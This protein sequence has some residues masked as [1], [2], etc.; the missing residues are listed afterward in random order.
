MSGPLADF[1][2]QLPFDP[3]PFQVEAAEAIAQGSSV[4]VTAPTG[5]GKTVVAEAAIHLALARGLR[6]FYTTPIKALSNQKFGDLIGQYGADRVGLLTGDN[7]IN[8]D[9]AI[10]VMTTE[11][12]RNMIYAESSALD[13]VAIVVL[14]EVHYLQDRARGAVWEEVIIHCP[15]EVQLVCLSAT[16]ANNTEF[17]ACWRERRGSGVLVSTEARPVPLEP[18]YM[19]KERSGERAVFFHPTFVDRD[20]RR[21][22]NPR[23][24]QLLSM[25][26]GRRRRFKTPNRAEVV[27]RLHR[28]RMLPAIYFIFSRAGCDAAAHRLVDAGIRLTT[29]EERSQIRATA[30]TR[31]AHLGDSDL[32]VLGY[33]RWI[34][35]LEAGVA[36]HHAGLVPAFKET[37]EEL[38]SA[39]LVK[40]VFATET[41]ALGINM[42]ARSVVLENL[43][44]YDGEGHQL[45]RPGDY[46][47]LTGRAGRRGIDTEG[48]GV[49][50]HSPFVRFGQVLEI[51]ATGRHRLTSSFRPTYNMTANLV[52]NYPENQA[53]ELL[54][55]SFA[56]F[57]REGDRDQAHRRIAA[58]EA[59]LTEEEAQARCDRGSVEEYEAI[60]ESTRPERHNDRIASLMRSGD[61]VDIAG[62]PRDGR[63]AV[64]K[65]LSRKGGGT[66]Y[67]VLSTSGRVSTMGFRE[68][69][70]G[71]RHVG[72]IDLPSPLRP[73]ERRFLQETLRRLRKLSLRESKDISPE[74]RAVGH[75]VA[76]CPDAAR[77]L[78]ALRRARRTRRLLEQH[79]TLRRSSGH[80]LVEEFHAI[81]SLLGELGY[82]SGWSL[83]PRGERL[84][85]IY[86]ETDLLLTEA[87]ERGYLLDLEPAELTAHGYRALIVDD[88]S[89]DGT[90]DLAEE[91]AGTNPLLRVLHREKKEGLGP[92]Y[93]AGFDAALAHGAEVVVEMD[94]D[95]SHDPAD[96]PRLVEAV[97]EGADLAIGS[98]YVPGG[99][100]PDWPWS[101]R[102]VSRG[103]N[104]YARVMLGIPV[105]DATAGFRAFARDSLTK[106]PYREAEAAGYGF[107]V[108]MAWRAHQA[109]LR[110]VEVPI[111]FRDRTRGTSKMGVRIVTEA[112]GLVTVWGL[113]RWWR[114]LPF[115]SR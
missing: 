66:R 98:R 24:Q 103:G 43:S 77:H 64:L 111:T 71:S 9:A 8:G 45:L 55:A 96:L 79:R 49:V 47:Q 104:L 87:V 28:E 39:G 53:E 86:N 16:I 99:G 76:E 94:A 13:D 112:M 61:V 78:D 88:S 74:R 73:K 113:G 85:R 109:G 63:Y 91:L 20:G 6:A 2:P 5:S 44:K 58:L 42:P 30:E 100:T 34:A 29:A 95:F 90:G 12:L 89:P 41:L 1:W 59:R 23:L 51:A 11:V 105:R 27:E 115:V 97:E 67:L 69:T 17:A 68:I 114:R 82:L 48:F 19:M 38:F 65:K 37:V 110:V 35:A 31:I 10:V 22:P 14:D 62:G 70:S 46:T 106:L 92:A 21:R 56:A 102:L 18:M 15:E 33:D 3:D 93:A 107:Q 36:S 26:Q 60:V 50:L 84:R 75:P 57:Q 83:A 72:V 52:A 40:V 81:R 80:G 4:V 54:E 32:E 7:V 25:E 101:R 108:E